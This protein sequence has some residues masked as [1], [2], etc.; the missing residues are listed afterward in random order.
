MKKD[1]YRTRFLMNPDLTPDTR[2][3]DADPT[4][5][6]LVLARALGGHNAFVK[7]CGRDNN[8]DGHARHFATTKAGKYTHSFSFGVVDGKLTAYIK[9]TFER[10]TPSASIRYFGLPHDNAGTTLEWN[11]APLGLRSPQNYPVLNLA[12]YSGHAAQNRAFYIFAKRCG[13]HIP[14]MDVRTWRQTEIPYNKIHLGSAELPTITPT[15]FIMP[16][17]SEYP[18]PDL[19]S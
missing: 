7:C 6:A 4:K 15:V 3:N 13:V 8:S 18:S 12:Y 1:F 5:Q 17:L 10:I 16:Q 9:S 14:N 19:I 11:E 2:Y